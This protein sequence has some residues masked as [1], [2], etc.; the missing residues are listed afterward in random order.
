MEVSN[1]DFKIQ[2]MKKTKEKERPKSH[3][4][5]KHLA[6]LLQTNADKSEINEVMGSDKQTWK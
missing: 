4:D 2:K 5:S 1:C 6:Y 3:R